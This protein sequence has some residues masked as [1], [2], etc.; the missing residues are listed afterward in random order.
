MKIHMR[1]EID[2]IIERIEYV[3]GPSSSEQPVGLHEPCF[4]GTNAWSYVKECLDSGWVSTAGSWVNQF[5][6]KLCAVTGAKHAV[7]VSSGTVALR[8]GLHVLGVSP[9]DEVIIPPLSFIATAN[10]V[11]HLGAI[12]HFVDIEKETLGLCPVALTSRLRAIAERR[13]DIIVNKET[14]RRIAAVLPVHVFGNPAK[15]DELKRVSDSWGIPMVEDAAEALA[16]YRD[17]THCGLFGSV[18]V[19]SFNGNKLITTG[20]GGA[21]LTNNAELAER[22]KHLST[23]AKKPHRWAFEHDE[24]A[25]NDRLPNINAALGVAQLENLEKRLGAKRLLAKEYKKAFNDMRKIELIQA[26]KRDITNNW[27]I[28]L[29][30]KERDPY[31]AESKRNQVLEKAHSKGML[32]RPVWKLL[33]KSPMYRGCPSGELNIAENQVMRLLNIPSSPQLIKNW[34]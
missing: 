2:E 1:D 16:S 20:G 10:A 28:T 7:V 27:L 19:L 13:K 11:A 25:W 5:E 32:L 24:I 15:V 34:Q 4:E 14:G 30:F 8:L 22:A 12:P 26:A 33:N 9:E 23:T 29:R 31:E 17:E 3:A 18:G 21:L 6:E